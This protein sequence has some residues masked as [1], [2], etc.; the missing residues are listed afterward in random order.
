MKIHDRMKRHD[1]LLRH[2]VT[3]QE[4][5]GYDKKAFQQQQT[6]G[7]KALIF[8]VDKEFV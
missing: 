8:V 6:I 2:F 4:K 7:T 3:T 5:L 1:F